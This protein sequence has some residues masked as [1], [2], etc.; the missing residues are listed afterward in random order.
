MRLP[1]LAFAVGLY[2][3]IHLSLPI[4]VGG[5]IRLAVETWSSPRSLER[6]REAGVL[7]ASGLIAGAALLG[8][9]GA[10]IAFTLLSVTLLW[11]ISRSPRRRK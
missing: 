9:V 1:T 2:L 8:V 7:Y 4:M 10:A 11:V 3:P 6:R 5:L